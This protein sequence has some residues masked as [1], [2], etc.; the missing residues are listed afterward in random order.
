MA[1]FAEID[2]NNIVTRIIV[3]A[4]KFESTGESWC[5]NF[6]GGGTWKQTSYN[7]YGNVHA[8]G[9][10]PFRKNYA[11]VGSTYDETRDAFIPLKPFTSWTL[12]E[13]TCQWDCPAA[14]PD[15][16]KKYDWNETTTT[17][18]LNE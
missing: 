12:N 17:W 2:E 15:D 3:I 14:Y 10:T 16:G 11:I 1:H 18:D 8:L 5:T 7:T 13:T 4:D 6:T 9:G